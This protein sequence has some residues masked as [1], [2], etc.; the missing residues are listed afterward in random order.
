[1]NRAAMHRLLP[2]IAIVALALVPAAAASTSMNPPGLVGAQR[3]CQAQGLSV[4]DSG[5]ALCLKEELAGGS[6][7]APVTGGGSSSSTVTVHRAQHACAQQGLLP[8]SNGFMTCVN[9]K[10]TTAARKT[11]VTKG[12]SQGSNG[13]SRCVKQHLQAGN[14]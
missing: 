7:T 6:T 14:K 10:L 8:G 13:F 12:L 11:C 5:Y 4:G 3:A 9:K 1:M 2:A